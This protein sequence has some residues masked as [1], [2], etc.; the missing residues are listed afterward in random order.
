M[1]M[2]F[3]SLQPDESGQQSQLGCQ[4]E[5]WWLGELVPFSSFIWVNYSVSFPDKPV[6]WLVGAV[7]KEDNIVPTGSV[8]KSR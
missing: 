5:V 8:S 2:A 1:L 4:G 6:K 3:C 7:G